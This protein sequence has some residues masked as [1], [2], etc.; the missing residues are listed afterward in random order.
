[1]SCLIQPV[2]I[3]NT[4]D[5]TI[6]EYYKYDEKTNI[7]LRSLYKSDETRAN[8]RKLIPYYDQLGIFE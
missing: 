7:S 2:M 5:I 8:L 6:E 4:G 1:M 3:N